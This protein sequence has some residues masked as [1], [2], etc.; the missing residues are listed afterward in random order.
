MSFHRS[1]DPTNS[2]NALKEDGVLS[3]ILQFHKV[4]NV[5]QYSVKGTMIS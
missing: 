2:V 3:I 4:H 1:N 5:L